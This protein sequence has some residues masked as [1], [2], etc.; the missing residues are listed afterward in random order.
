[1]P[2]IDPDRS[3][4]EET[5]LARV[6]RLIPRRRIG[7]WEPRVGVRAWRVSSARPEDPTWRWKIA[8]E[9]TF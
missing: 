4:I 9:A 6:K 5:P 1:M 7:P 2:S 8:S 3:I